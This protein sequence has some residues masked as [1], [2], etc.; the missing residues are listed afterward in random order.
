MGW[1]WRR[2]YRQGPKRSR[3][4]TSAACGLAQRQPCRLRVPAGLLSPLP[5]PKDR[6]GTVRTLRPGNSQEPALAHPC[7]ANGSALDTR[8][9]NYSHGVKV[10]LATR[11]APLAH[12]SLESQAAS[13]ASPSMRLARVR[14]DTQA[15]STRGPSSQSPQAPICWVSFQRQPSPVPADSA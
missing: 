3:W 7:R 6:A 10:G 14:P 12:V 4:T 8:F 15:H 11:P 2:V 9:D 5:H 1:S 13:R